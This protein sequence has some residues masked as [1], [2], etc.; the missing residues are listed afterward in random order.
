M[1]K[2]AIARARQRLAK[3]TI[4]GHTL[5]HPRPADPLHIP[6]AAVDAS[7]SV[8]RVDTARRLIRAYKQTISQ[9]GYP[10]KDITDTDLWTGITRNNFTSMLE[11]IEKEDAEQ[12]SHFLVGF[13]KSYSWFG[14]LTTGLDGYNHWD[15]SGDAVAFSYF[16]KLVCLAEGLGV[17][18]AENPEHGAAGNWGRN[19]RL[20]ADLI[21]DKIAEAVGIDIL[22]PT[23]II[24]VAGIKLR[25]GP[26]HYRHINALYMAARIR[27]LTRESDRICEYGGGLGFVAFYLSRMGRPDTTLFDIPIVNVL[28]GFFLIGALGDDAVCLEGE[29][30]RAGTVKI[31]AN[32]RCVDAADGDFRI[33]ANQDSFPEINE[34]IF[35]A[36]RREIKRTSA[37]LL[38]INHEVER[39]ID[40]TVN[41]LNVSRLLSSDPEFRRLYRSPYW[42][43]RGYVE[44]LYRIEPGG[45]TLRDSERPLERF[46]F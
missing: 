1:F 7:W 12:L 21:A 2:H 22:P 6:F 29:S 32:W 39:E 20:D 14:G 30:P 17:L 23:G 38:S 35:D 26:L 19:I 24:P 8:K 46:A 33:A 16:D 34:A 42:L 15:T 10:L 28:S 36:Y 40:G 43:R 3:E 27:D 44:E 25:D 18:Q 9:S 13:G 45:E 37:F 5:T 41:H 31:S 11:M 4:Y